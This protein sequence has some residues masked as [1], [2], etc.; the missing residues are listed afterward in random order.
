M[1]RAT[2]IVGRMRSFADACVDRPYVADSLVGGPEEP[3]RLVILL[4]AFDCVT[5]VECALALARSRTPAGFVRELRRTR[6]RGGRVAWA[7]RL[8][9]FSDWLRSN[10][11]RG[12]VRIRTRGAGSRSIQA[13]LGFVPG[14]PARRVRFHVV[15]KRGL[16]QARRRL[17]DGAVI[18]FASVRARLDFFHT[19]LVFQ[20]EEG[21]TLFH[22][23]R[24]AGRV[25]AEPLG[26]FLG[27][28][29]MRGVAFASP[30]RRGGSR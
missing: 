8:H 2:G 15:P 24:S 27:R 10:Q 6:Y 7:A 29:R 16:R 28:N 23:S 21:M 19:G 30:L 5:F 9:Y 3:E 20:D 17:D 26:D 13:T 22:A 12:A 18:A 25:L 14:L 1:E 11:R 4:S